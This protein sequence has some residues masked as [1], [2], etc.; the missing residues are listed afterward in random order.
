MCNVCTYIEKLPIL[1]TRTLLNLVN[2]FLHEDGSKLVSVSSHP[3]FHTNR[4]HWRTQQRLRSIGTGKPLP[5]PWHSSR[6]MFSLRHY[7]NDSQSEYGE[8]STRS[9]GNLYWT[10]SVHLLFTCMAWPMDARCGFRVKVSQS[11]DEP[12]EGRI[13]A[14]A[15]TATAWRPAV[16]V[17][18]SVTCGCPS[19][20]VG[21]DSGISLLGLEKKNG[22]D[23]ATL[24]LCEQRLCY[25]VQSF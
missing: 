2:S 16:V 6:C 4:V 12:V 11:K 13:V 19:F 15:P 21:A 7:N 3:A 1:T 10:T 22:Q 17:V 20:S 25:T 14:G 9:L 8:F 5:I 23:Q 18:V 24:W